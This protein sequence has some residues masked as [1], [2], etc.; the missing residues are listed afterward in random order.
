MACA[1]FLS[2]KTCAGA[3]LREAH[4]SKRVGLVIEQSAAGHARDQRWQKFGKT[5][6]DDF[7]TAVERG[8]ASET[9][10][11]LVM[12]V[13]SIT[14]AAYRRNQFKPTERDIQLHP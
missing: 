10:R 3:P 5:A 9:H 7:A 1:A 14:E 6:A 4:D 11:C 2:K 13:G 12:L 8:D